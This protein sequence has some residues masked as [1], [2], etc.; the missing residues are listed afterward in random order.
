MFFP[1]ADSPNPRFTPRVTLALIVINVLVHLALVPS[2]WQRP[3]ADDPRLRGYVQ[4]LVGEER[5]S[6]AQVRAVVGQLRVRDLV[7]FEHG[8][9]PGA[10]ELSDLLASMFL[11][12]GWLHLLGNM[13]FLWIFGDNLE[14]RLGRGGFLLFYLGTGLLASFGDALLRPGS[15]IPAVGASGAISG[16][17]G[18]YFLWFPHNRVRVLAFLFPLLV[19]VIEVR[20]RIVL[21]F[22]VVVQNLLPL[23]LSGGAG[24]VSYG[25]HLG[26][27]LAGLGAAAIVD[28][29]TRSAPRRSGPRRVPPAGPP[30]PTLFRDLLEQQRWVEAAALQLDSVRARGAIPLR[31]QLELAEAL[32]LRAEPRLALA[33]AEAALTAWPDEPLSASFHLVAARVLLRALG[34]PTA[35][36]QHLRRATLTASDPRQARAAQVLLDEL[37]RRTLRV[38]GDARW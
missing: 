5:V 24:G 7:V 32:E 17:L 1:F 6:A 4:A 34:Q 36:Y 21:G 9:R 28:A 38:P 18:G 37:S 20:A 26:G 29:W 10:P 31:D 35:A 8:F 19:D 27:F 2:G 22:Y 23:L 13:L 12:G 14:H 30:S 15:L 16:V 3:E 25:A 11:H 33:V